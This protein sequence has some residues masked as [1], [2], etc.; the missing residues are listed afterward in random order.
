MYIHGGLEGSEINKIQQRAEIDKNLKIF[1]TNVIASSVNIFVDNVLVFNEVVDGKDKLGQKELEYKTIDNNSLLQM[2][3][4]VGRFKAGRAVLL[5]D[6]P[7]P[8]VIT[9]QR[10][11]KSLERETP[12]DLVLLMSKYGLKLSELEFMSKLNL[13]ELEFAE[14][15]LYEIGAIEK[16]THSITEKGL[17]MSEIPYDPDFSHMVSRAI[18]EEDYDVARFL[19]ASGSF[20]DSLNHSYKS[21]MEAV[22]NEFLY[23]LDKTSELNIKAK[24]LSKY[25]TDTEGKFISTLVVNGVFPRFV[26]E[27]WKNFEAARDSLNDILR[28]RRSEK[29]T[30]SREILTDVENERLRPYLEDCLTFERFYLHEAAEFGLGDD[31]L[32]SISIEGDF[33][34]RSLKMNY[35]KILYDIVAM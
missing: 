13:N 19:L 4:R 30:I 10:V 23:A 11:R 7:I 15:W 8:K 12:F 24:L 25:S 22:A 9:P 29:W 16:K 26:D 31:A 33:F 32:G 28:E 35:R 17:L 14:S 27:A 20:G 5:S 6:T 3:G 2:M 21:E 34:A 1:A 18:L